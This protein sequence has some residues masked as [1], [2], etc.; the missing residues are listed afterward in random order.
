MAKVSPLLFIP[1]VVFAGL[2]ALFLWGMGRSDPDAMP[3]AR[4]GG[5]APA[6]T[7]TPLGTLPG[8]D[9]AALGAPGVKVVN[10]WASWCAPCRA[11]HPMLERL[12]AQGLTIYGVNYKDDP[13]KALGFLDELGNPYA[14][15][16]ADP[17]GRTGLDWGLYGVPE[18]F[19]IDGEGKVLLRFAG[20]LGESVMEDTVGPAL[21]G[22]GWVAKAP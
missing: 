2:A 21:A 17:R 19:V 5:P 12:A 16:V 3:S 1:P 18:T 7:V 4:A 8:F 15:A 6:L 14:A 9:A 11:E 22:A 13:A 10:F 20:P